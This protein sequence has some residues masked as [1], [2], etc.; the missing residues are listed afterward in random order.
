M[1][2]QDTIE[3][4]DDNDF[5]VRSQKTVESVQQPIEH[6]YD[7][8]ETRSQRTVRS[9]QESIDNVCGQEE[10]NSQGTFVEDTPQD[11]E[12]ARMQTPAHIRK[13][14]KAPP[15]QMEGG[16]KHPPSSREG[17][18]NRMPPQRERSSRRM[19]S[20]D[21]RLEGG[22]AHSTQMKEMEGRTVPQSQ[23]ITHTDLTPQRMEGGQRASPLARTQRQEEIKQVYTASD[24]YSPELPSPQ[25]WEKDSVQPS[26]ILEE[27][28]KLRWE[29]L[30]EQEQGVMEE[31]M[32]MAQML[33][34]A[35][36]A[37]Q[38]CRIQTWPKP[39]T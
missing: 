33:L 12:V 15:K 16:H 9:V 29:R 3:D 1:S 25:H 35:K 34:E 32:K 13:P 17:S 18:Y 37:R 11:W 24:G 22:A 31:E 36:V 2:A 20:V 26:P 5:D 19:P 27:N 4:F 38:I 6:I 14:E 39:P 21:T 28:L 10:L 23:D 7:R 8:E 30:R